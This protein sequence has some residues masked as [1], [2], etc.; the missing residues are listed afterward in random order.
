MTVDKAIL[1]ILETREIT[2]QAQLLESLQSEGY[3][4]TQ[5]TLSRHLKKLTVQKREGRYQRVDTPAPGIV[6]FQIIE[7]PPNLIVLKTLPG[8]AQALAST[9][10]QRSLQGIAGSVAGDDTIFIALKSPDLL[11]PLKE[12][13]EKLQRASL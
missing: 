12:A 5:P 8:F 7:A 9:L 2:D 11:T 13:L 1:H 6:P 3:D 10:D 4:L